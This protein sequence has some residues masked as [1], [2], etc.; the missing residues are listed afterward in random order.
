MNAAITG[1]N[2][3]SSSSPTQST[4]AKRW[5]ATV[6]SGIEGESTVVKNA[7]ALMA[8]TRRRTV[9]GHGSDHSSPGSGSTRPDMIKESD[10]RI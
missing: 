9:F 3:F 2:A 6:S 5:N 1:S 4:R 7:L 8:R 10:C